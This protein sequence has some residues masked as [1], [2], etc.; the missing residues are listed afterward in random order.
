LIHKSYFF[1]AK[2]SKRNYFYDYICNFQGWR[3]GWITIHDSNNVF[4][5]GGIPNGLQS[6]S[7]RILGANTIVQ[8]ALQ[9]ILE[10][11][12]ES[13]YKETLSFIENNARLAFGRLAAIPGLKPVLPDV[14]NF[15][16]ILRNITHVIF[17]SSVIF[18]ICGFVLSYC[19]IKIRFVDSILKKKIQKCSICVI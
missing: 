3:L 14:N 6:L 7:Q 2:I 9:S 4:S 1:F 17:K 19:V 11:T 18:M 15:F 8:G 13:F 5:D 16:I 10:E 12:P